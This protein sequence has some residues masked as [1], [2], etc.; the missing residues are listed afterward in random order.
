MAICPQRRCVAFGCAAGIELHWVDALTGHDLHRWFPLAAPSDFLFF[1]PPRP[2]LDSARKLRL[3]SSTQMPDRLPAGSG[4]SP[5]STTGGAPE[6]RHDR[7]RAA[8][9]TFRAVPLSDG[10][11]VVFT[12]P[13]SGR[14][15]VGADAPNGRPC[16]LSRK[17]VLQGPPFASA[18]VY[19]VGRDL[20]WGA[21]V[22]AAFGDELWMFSVPADV[23][24]CEGN[25]LNEPW[26][27]NYAASS[28]SSLQSATSSGPKH[29]DSAPSI[30]D[31]NDESASVWPVT[32][33]GVPVA[34]VSQLAELAIDSRQATFTIWAFARDGMVRAWQV[35][36]AYPRDKRVKVVH[37]DGS[38]GCAKNHHEHGEAAWVST[39]DG[40][41]S[42]IE[43]DE[44]GDVIMHDAPPL[45]P[46]ISEPRLHP[47]LR[48]QL[49]FDGSRSLAPG[50]PSQSLDELTF[51]PA[52]EVRPVIGDW[53]HDSDRASLVPS[54]SSPPE[55][56]TY[57]G[58]TRIRFQLGQEPNRRLNDTGY[59]DDGEPSDTDVRN[60][61]RRVGFGSISHTARHIVPS[62]AYPSINPDLSLPTTGATTASRFAASVTEDLSYGSY[63]SQNDWSDDRQ[64]QRDSSIGAHRG[65]DATEREWHRRG[66]GI[67][68]ATWDLGALEVEITA[69]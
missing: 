51:G 12:D 7:A 47:V 5:A 36:G 41:R 65:N 21:R 24:Q 22:V 42:D 1:L 10:V 62:H 39:G 27:A 9:D 30:S 53:E 2:G 46:A 44:D 37:R 4:P 35:R 63:S 18:A 11:H 16:R 64:R 8:A 14:I 61:N 31:N 38:I 6:G 19:A 55:S 49:N 3:V 32:I 43:R 60:A 50:S 25:G 33:H 67:M 17:I 59:D 26:T 48:P 13:G 52:D 23:L 40:G 34:T 68:G 66:Y 45:D 28:Q 29:S 20:R 69:L 56:R 57:D 58:G 54:A 15:C